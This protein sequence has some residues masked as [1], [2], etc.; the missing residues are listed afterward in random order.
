MLTMTL[1]MMTLMMITM[2][3]MVDDDDDSINDH[4]GDQQIRGGDTDSFGKN[5]KGRRFD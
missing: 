4:E 1:M 5:K 3:L 2:T